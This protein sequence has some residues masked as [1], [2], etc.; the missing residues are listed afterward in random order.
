MHTGIFTTYTSAQYQPAQALVYWR[1][2]VLN[3][4]ALLKRHE[5]YQVPSKSFNYFVLCS[6]SSV[7]AIGK[8]S[9]DHIILN[10]KRHSIALQ[11]LLII[12]WPQVAPKH[13][14]LFQ[15]VKHM[16]IGWNLLRYGDASLNYLQNDKDQS[17]AQAL[18]AFLEIDE[19][20]IAGENGVDAIIATLNHLFKKDSTI[21]KYQAFES[22]LTCQIPSTM[23]IQ[24]FLNEFDKHLFKTKTYGPTMSDEIL[25]YQLLKSENLSSHHEKLI[26]KTIPN[27]LH[28]RW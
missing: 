11:T 22:L 13:H 19:A 7:V 1:M 21:T 15:S 27:Y 14:Y 25:A 24:A 17:L 16:K 23:S 9:T 28:N 10:Q 6:I 8:R 12:K 20:E 18:D 26:K 4:L 3:I 2:L 5:T